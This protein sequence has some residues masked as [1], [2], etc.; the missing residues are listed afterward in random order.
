MAKRTTRPS[1]ASPLGEQTIKVFNAKGK[2]LKD[3]DYP[4]SFPLSVGNGDFV[5]TQD[6]QGTYHF[7]L[8][9]NKS[10]FWTGQEW[11]VTG[12]YTEFAQGSM[13]EAELYRFR[14]KWLKRGGHL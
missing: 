3:R 12:N 2:H 5:T 4:T 11:R 9:W 8:F 13:S 14:R 1:K 7:G 10:I 6:A